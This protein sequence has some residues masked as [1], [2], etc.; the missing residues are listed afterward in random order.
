[1][2]ANKNRDVERSRRKIEAAAMRIFTKQGYYG[3]SIREIISVGNLY[4]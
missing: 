4:N 1:M 3:T 2:T